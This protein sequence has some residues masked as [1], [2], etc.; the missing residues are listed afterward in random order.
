MGGWGIVLAAIASLVVAL[1][2]RTKLPAPVVALALAATS[3][4]L[5]W[6]GISLRPDPSTGERVL[7]IGAMAVLGPAHAW[8]VLGRFGPRRRWSR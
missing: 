8:V 4:A 7:A 2:L 5:A 6:S 3:A 1:G